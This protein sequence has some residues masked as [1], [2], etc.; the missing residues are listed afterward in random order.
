MSLDT[1]W[2]YIYIYILKVGFE[3]PLYIDI[4]QSV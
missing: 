1:D 2:I 3:I 4:T